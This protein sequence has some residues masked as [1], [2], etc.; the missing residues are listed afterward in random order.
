M[1]GINHYVTSDRFLDDQIQ[2]YPI[3]MHGGN[4]RHRYVD[5]ESVRVLGDLPGGMEAQIREAWQRYRLPVAVTEV[6]LGCTR[7]EQLRWLTSAWRPAQRVRAEGADIRAVT[8]W[9]A[10]GTMDWDSLL[11]ERNGT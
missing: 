11:C 3:A 2:N 6:H 9:A 10:F 4:G 5:V 1:V 8:A 7:E